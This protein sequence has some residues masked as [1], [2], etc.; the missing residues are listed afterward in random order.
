MSSNVNKPILYHGY[1]F[2]Y[3]ILNG[4]KRAEDCQKTYHEY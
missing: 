2:E 1:K 4:W 3:S